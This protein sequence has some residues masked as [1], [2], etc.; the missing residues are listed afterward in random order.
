M[1]FTQIAKSSRPRLWIGICVALAAG[2]TGAAME[3]DT[4]DTPLRVA[5]AGPLVQID[6]ARQLQAGNAAYA[7]KE[8]TEALRIFRNIAVLGVPEAHYRLGIMYAEGLGT[9]KSERQ[10]EYW[11]KLASRKNYPGAASALGK[12]RTSSPDS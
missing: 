7:R 8:Y 1:K 9:R 2:P 4:L 6:P 10:A 12:L 11:L 5:D 3:P